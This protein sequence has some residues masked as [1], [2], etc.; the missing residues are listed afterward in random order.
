DPD[1]FT[2]GFGVG[3]EHRRGTDIGEI[4]RPG[5]NRFH[6]ART[7]VVD[8]PFDLCSRSEPLLKPAF[9]LPSQR[10]SH[11]ALS[12]SDVREMSDSNSG[13]ALRD[14]SQDDRDHQYTKNFL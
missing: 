9:A 12:M 14:R 8:E 1:L 7:S 10:M 11:D 3:V 2:L 13:V 6:R 4:N 5:K